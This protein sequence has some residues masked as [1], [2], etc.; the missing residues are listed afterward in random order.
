MASHAGHFEGQSWPGEPTP[1][2]S[3]YLG[4]TQIVSGR[5]EV[6]ARMSRAEGEG[7]VTAEIVPGQT[8]RALPSIPNRFWIPEMPK[9]IDREWALSIQTGHEYYLSTTL[10]YL[11]RRFKS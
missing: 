6:L 7:I 10:P 2:P 9:E 3:E 8:S 11:K 1:F 5:G 4:E